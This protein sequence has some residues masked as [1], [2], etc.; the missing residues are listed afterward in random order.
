MKRSKEN[1]LARTKA[2]AN[3]YKSHIESVAKL[4]EILKKYDNQKMTLV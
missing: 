4:I 3:L 1:Y 2:L